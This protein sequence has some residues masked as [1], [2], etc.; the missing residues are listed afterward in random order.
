MASLSDLPDELLSLIGEESD[1]TEQFV[2]ALT[3]RRLHR[4]VNP[5]LYKDNI[6]KDDGNA[7]FWAAR[8]GRLDTLEL[9]RTYG[10]EWNDS[11]GS[12][13]HEVYAWAFPE[14]EIEDVIDDHDTFFSPLH[15]AA[16]FGQTSAA[17][18]LL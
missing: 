11:N 17:R 5:I 8:H 4:I 10:A 7:V 16:K 2:L 6:T 18:W 15:I 12:R 1:P 3:S 13:N 14:K 9:L